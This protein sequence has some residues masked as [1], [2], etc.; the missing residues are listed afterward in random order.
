MISFIVLAFTQVEAI[1]SNDDFLI[2]DGLP[3]IRLSLQNKDTVRVAYFGGSI[4]A[5]KGW[6]IYSQE[7]LKAKYPQSEIVEI[8]AAIGGC[9]SDFGVFRLKEHAL[10]FDPDLVFVEFAVND[11]G[12]E[13]AT[14]IK[15]ME[16]IVRQIWETDATTDICF[17]YTIAM[18]FLKEYH[19]GSLPQ[20]VE[21]MEKVAAHYGIPSMNFGPEV[22]RQIDDGVLQFKGRI[23]DNDHV[24]VF[25]PDGVHP[26]PETGHRIY[27]SVFKKSFSKII[28]ASSDGE[29]IHGVGTPLDERYYGNTRMVKWDE[30]EG[31]EK[32]DNIDASS[33]TH[34]NGFAKYFRTIGNA[35]PGD[36]VVFRFVG[37][38]FGFYDLKT[39]DSGVLLLEIDGVPTDTIPRFD[40]YTTYRR[41]S[42]K[43]ITGLEHKRHTVVLRVLDKKLDKRAIL[44]EL[45]NSMRN[46]QEYEGKNWYLAKLMI[47]GTLLENEK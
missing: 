7:W 30:C 29:M 45:G 46:P 9:G 6:R 18:D 25:S 39:P 36:S 43:L 42:Y 2:R 21:T 20:S 13:P 35:V 17:V 11:G 41:I 27:E 23:T 47:N 10:R 14:I 15:A 40:K 19:V 3:N 12:T 34:F 4:T 5:Q 8:D 31:T 44:S 24:S 16:G 37:D 33:N 38:A 32:W 1:T 26:Y 28:D 22:I